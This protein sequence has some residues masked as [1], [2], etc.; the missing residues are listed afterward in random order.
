[1]DFRLPGLDDGPMRG[2]IL[3][4]FRHR[5]LKRTNRLEEPEAFNRVP[6]GPS[7]H[8]WMSFY[9][10]YTRGGRPDRFAGA[11]ENVNLPSLDVDL[12]CNTTLE[13]PE[14]IDGRDAD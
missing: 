9:S 14:R 1:M 12:D 10:N 5:E 2:K 7:R 11:T 6:A 4:A 3:S 13:I 8:L